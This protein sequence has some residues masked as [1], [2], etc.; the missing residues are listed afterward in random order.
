[1]AEIRRH[2]RRTALEAATA[3]SHLQYGFD[4]S[5]GWLSDQVAWTRTAG[6]E[7]EAAM[8]ES[9]HRRLEQ[10]RGEAL[11]LLDPALDGRQRMPDSGAWASAPAA[12]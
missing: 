7:V 10:L 5:L 6:A 12:E 9:L 3:Q 4:L 8:W 2:R 11:A 1:M